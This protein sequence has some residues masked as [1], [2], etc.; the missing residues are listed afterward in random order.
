MELYTESNGDFLSLAGGKL[1]YRMTNSTV[2]GTMVYGIVIRCSLFSDDETVLIEAISSDATFVQKLMAL[3]ADNAVTPCCA[4]EV[5][6][7]Y[8]AACYTV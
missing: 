6:E 5:V 2:D 3:L 1:T 4:R 7:D 8:I